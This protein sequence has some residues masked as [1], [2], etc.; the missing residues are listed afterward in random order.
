MASS[1]GKSLTELQRLVSR[2]LLDRESAFYLTGGAALAGYHLG[3][4][5][6]SDLDLF[7]LDPAAFER[8]RHVLAEVA[9]VLAAKMEIVQDTPGFVRA[10]LTTDRGALVV[11][12]VRE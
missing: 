4:R 7:T 3:H 9:D 2:A 1:S 12:L 6:T 10:V 11:D 5:E 8:A